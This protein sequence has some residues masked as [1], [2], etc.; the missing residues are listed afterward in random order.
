MEDIKELCEQWLAIKEQEQEVTSWRRDV[1]DKI[2]QRLRL[3][4][5]D[6]N[7][8]KELEGFKIQATVRKTATVDPQ[9]VRELS[10][11][12]ELGHHLMSL[13][14]WE[15]KL[16]VKEWAKCDPDVV[17]KLSPAINHKISRPSLKIEKLGE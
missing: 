16:N 10:D 1:E 4:D 13:F 8:T 14:R 12:H 5:L 7:A 9:H 11:Q 3:S 15:A 2:K 17:D 6:K